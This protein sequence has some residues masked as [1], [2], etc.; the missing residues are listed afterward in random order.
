MGCLSISCIGYIILLAV[1]SAAVKIFATCL[2]CSGVYP[3]VVL[4]ATWLGINTGGY[5]KRATTWAMAEI[6]GNCFSIMGSH[7][8]TD[9]PRYIKGHSTVLALLIFSLINTVAVYF[10]MKRENQKKDIVE[11]EYRDRGD[12]HPDAQKSLEEAYDFHVAFR[13]TL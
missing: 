8:Y 3:A 11:Q 6:F 4:I 5:T 2:V 1:E 13:Y 7:I 10:W 12:V 9:A